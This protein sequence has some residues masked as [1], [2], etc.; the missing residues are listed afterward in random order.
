MRD[1]RQEFLEKR[2]QELQGSTDF[3]YNLLKCITGYA[4]IVGDFDGNIIVFNDGAK[5]IFGFDPQDVVGLKNIEDFYPDHLVKAGILNILFDKLL[6]E[7]ECIFELDRTRKNG[8][9]FPGQSL[10]TLVQDNEGRLVGFVEISEDITERKQKEKKIQELYEKEK[11]H[12]QELEVSEEFNRGLLI[13]APNPILVTGLDN[14]VI[15]ANPALEKLTGFTKG[16]II[17]KT[18]P[19]PWWPQDM[20]PDHQVEEVPGIKPESSKQEKC[21]VKRNGESF[22]VL[23]T[24][25]PVKYNGNIKYYLANLVDFTE[26][27]KTQ[28]QLERA[29]KQLLELD[30]LKDN[31]ISMVSHELRT[32][33]T[34]IKSFTEILLNYEEDRTTQKEFLR[35]IDS[36]SDRLLRLINDFL[37]I[38]KIQAGRMQWQKA[39][40]SLIDVIQQ[41][42]DS[43]RPLIEEAKLVLS[44]DLQPGLPPVL[45]DKDRLIQVVTNLLSNSIKFTPE[46]GNII[47]KSWRENSLDTGDNEENIIVSISDS[48]IGIAPENFG[49]I[50]ENFGQVGNSLKNKPKGTGLGLPICK[51]II[52]YFGGKIWVESELGKG[53]TFFFSLPLVKEPDQIEIV[54]GKI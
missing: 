19:Y 25:E 9:L 27:K 28:D 16:E 44:T 7:G 13:N 21:Y 22:W 23:Q 33:L 36:E 8:E 39:R 31:F 4:V 50:F 29:N 40:L 26:R 18:P 17:G 20:M 14:T 53:S 41:A 47:V 48:G 42:A 30:K 11:R 5:K 49:L 38:S 34:S 52:E 6:H 12:R 1:I 35:I 24:V 46:S 15:H 10:L 51:K 37:D 54:S 2:I 43:L 3:V 32:P 45:G